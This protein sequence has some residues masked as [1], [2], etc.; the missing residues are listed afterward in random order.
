MHEANGGRGHTDIED[1]NT[2]PDALRRKMRLIHLEDDYDP[3]GSDIAP[4]H[5]GEVLEL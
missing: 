2:L 3:A 5:E 1:L 4:L